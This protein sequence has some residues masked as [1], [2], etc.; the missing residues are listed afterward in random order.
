MSFSYWLY[1][2]FAG[3]KLRYKPGMLVGGRRLV[4]ECGTGR[5]IGYF[6]EPLIVLGLF[7]KKPLS[8]SLRGER[9]FNDTAFFFF[10]FFLNSFMCIVC[11]A[12][13]S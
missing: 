7:G 13:Y 2:C 4:H 9:R 11:F 5:A 6:L 3:T 12:E 8:I 10:F 1:I